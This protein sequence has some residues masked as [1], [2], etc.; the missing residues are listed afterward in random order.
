MEAFLDVTQ[1][2]GDIIRSSRSYIEQISV[3]NNNPPLDPLNDNK[4][5]DEIKL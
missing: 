4:D 5:K 2:L 3:N 1:N